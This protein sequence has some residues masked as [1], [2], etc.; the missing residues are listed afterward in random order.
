MW[1]AGA[2]ANNLSPISDMDNPGTAAYTGLGLG[3]F[4]HNHIVLTMITNVP[5]TATFEY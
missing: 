1:S 2:N 4:Y 5:T 3:S